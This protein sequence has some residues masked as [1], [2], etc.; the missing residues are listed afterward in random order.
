M[1]H[2]LRAGVRI[3]LTGA[4][5]RAEAHVFKDEDIRAIEAAYLTGRP[6]L[7]KGEPG[8]GKS[9]FARAAAKGLKRDFRSKVVDAT[10]QS[11]DLLWDTDLIERLAQAQALG[12]GGGKGVDDVEDHLDI[13]RFI[14]PGVFWWGFNPG[15]TTDDHFYRGKPGVRSKQRNR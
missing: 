6:L 8:V 5:G 12:A 4:G 15:G 9:Q 13:R 7:L 3:D 2:D 10:T 1:K 14:N 11:R